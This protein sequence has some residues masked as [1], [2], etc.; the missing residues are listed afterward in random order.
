MAIFIVLS[1]R[2]SRWV[3]YVRISGYV[4]SYIDT[5]GKLLG[6]NNDSLDETSKTTGTIMIWRAS[7]T[8]GHQLAWGNPA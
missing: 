1:A 3:F 6:S 8:V 4:N 7:R 2:D 5:C